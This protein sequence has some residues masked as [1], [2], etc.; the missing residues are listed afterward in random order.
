MLSVPIAGTPDTRIRDGR[1]QGMSLSAAID[2]PSNAEAIE[3]TLESITQTRR[4]DISRE[5]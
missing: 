5:W 1:T 4:E 3:G 2:N